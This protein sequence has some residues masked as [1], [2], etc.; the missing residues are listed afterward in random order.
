MKLMDL[1][2]QKYT[3]RDYVQDGLV[4]MWD[5]IEN[6]GWGTHDDAATV[7]KDLTGNGNDA[8][9]VKSESYLRSAPLTVLRQGWTERSHSRSPRRRS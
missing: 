3:A 4:A 9:I 2:F 8:T 7:W 1:W 6:A 5:G